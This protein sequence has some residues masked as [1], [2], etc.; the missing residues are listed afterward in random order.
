[1]KDLQNIAKKSSYLSVK[2][3]VDTILKVNNIYYKSLLKTIKNYIFENEIEK[4]LFYWYLFK[5]EIWMGAPLNDLGIIEYLDGVEN[6]E[7]GDMKGPHG[8]IKEGY[9]QLI[10]NLSKNLNI[11][12]KKEVININFIDQETIQVFTKDN[13]I[14]S[15]KYVICTIPLNVIKKNMNQLFNPSLSKEKLEII[16]QVKMGFYGKIILLFSDYFWKD[17]KNYFFGCISN[18][19]QE[20]VSLFLDY[21]KCKE[22]PILIGFVIDKLAKKIETMTE[23][24]VIKLTMKSLYKIFG[25]KIPNPKKVLI[26]KWNTDEFSLGSYTYL[27]VGILPEE[28]N[29][30]IKPVIVFIKNKS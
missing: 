21:F 29:K 30:L 3:S 25:E 16:Q 10:E 23:N 1:M 22:K 7:W 18:N 4:K 11:Q 5:Q 15:C 20:E 9:Y 8:L 6:N 12:Q 19:F 14:F 24:E 17:I 2:E 13:N 28:I 27:P 26:T